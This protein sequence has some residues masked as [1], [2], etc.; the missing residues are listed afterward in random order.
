MD[1]LREL[2]QRRAAEWRQA[3]ESDVSTAEPTPPPDCAG[4]SQQRAASSSSGGVLGSVSGLWSAVRS[5]NID[6]ALKSVTGDSA[7]IA[8][9]S[10]AIGVTPGASSSS[11]TSP[12]GAKA[13]RAAPASNSHA[14]PASPS[15]ATPASNSGAAEH[16]ST[17][18]E[19]DHQQDEDRSAVRC[20]RICFDS[21]EAGPSGQLFSPCKCAGS[22]RFVHVECLN[23]WRIAS[24]NERSYYKCDQC[25]YEYRLER[26]RAA[27]FLASRDAQQLLTALIF[28][29]SGCLLGVIA[30]LIY[31][32]LLDTAVD[33]LELPPALRLLFTSEVT[34]GH[35]G[36][37]Y[38]GASYLE[39]CGHAEHGNPACWDEQR[40]FQL[41]CSPPGSDLQQQLRRAFVPAF[42]LFCTGGIGLSCLGFAIYIW[43]QVTQNWGDSN[44]F[45]QIAFFIM[46]L[47][48]F[49]NKAL[50][51]IVSV[52]GAAVAVR[53]LYGILQVWAK[54]VAARIGDRVL[55]VA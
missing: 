34:D 46:W 55:E 2:R 37:W 8:A 18:H 49:Q 30:R 12:S 16:T 51:R 54:Q 47:C 39:C 52:V 13:Y 3:R 23:S 36:C 1:E 53:E 42:R 31:P 48:H 33:W 14:T 26:V 4:G 50:G 20:C 9:I 10:A 19:H 45:M 29:T 15:G 35:A 43:N 17:S 40:D 11:S 24:Q 44:G 21:D 41:C 38:A 7:H 28:V 25:H 32:M 27:S 6:S 5:G 22:M